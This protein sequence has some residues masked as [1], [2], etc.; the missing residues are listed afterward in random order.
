M[1]SWIEQMISQ[2]GYFAIYLLMII[3]NVFPPI[4]SEIILPLTGVLSADGT[5]SSVAA[6]LVASAGAMTGAVFWYWVGSRFDEKRLE[7]FVHHHGR[8][9]GLTPPEYKKITGFFKRHQSTA[10][11]L[12]HLIPG[13]RSFISIPAGLFKMGK[14]KFF[15]SSILGITVWNTFLHGLGYYFQDSYE[16]VSETVDMVANGIIGV[17]VL[18]YIYKVIRYKPPEDKI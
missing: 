15:I 6:I 7:H 18:V 12:A 9:V 8:W 5:L 13:F 2:F 14:M 1:V 17:L 11:F 3:E 4:P 10:V 16:T